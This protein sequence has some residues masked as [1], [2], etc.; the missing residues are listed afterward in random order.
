[1]KTPA[2]PVMIAKAQPSDTLMRPDASGRF[3]VRFIKAS[4]SFSTTWLMAFALPVTSIPPAKSKNIIFHLF[5]KLSAPGVSKKLIT[6]LNT[7]MILSEG[8]TNCK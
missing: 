5:T 6:L 8:F 1:M 2:A 7:T 4:V 3:A